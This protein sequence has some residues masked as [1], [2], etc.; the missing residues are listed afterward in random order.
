MAITTS[1][2]ISKYYEAFKTT[3]VTF[4]KEVIQT[5]ALQ[6]QQIF[7]KCVGEQWPCVIYSASLSG[8]KVLASA[9]NSL[10][11]RIKRAN[12]V[13]SLRFSFKVSDKV[14]PR[15]FFVSGKVSG[16]APYAAVQRGPPVHQYQVY[17]EASG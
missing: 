11:D 1:Q 14:D 15:A 5:T 2:Q 12:D 7:L 4:T 3:D 13:V 10:G 9:K 16:F 17:P 8:A 6:P